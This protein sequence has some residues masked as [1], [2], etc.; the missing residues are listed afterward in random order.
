MFTIGGGGYYDILFV[1]LFYTHT[2][3]HTHTERAM[4]RRPPGLSCLHDPDKGAVL[5]TP[6][7]HLSANMLSVIFCAKA[8]AR[9]PRGSPPPLPPAH[10]DRTSPSRTRPSVSLSLP[11]IPPPCFF[12]STFARQRQPVLSPRS[13]IHFT[14]C[15]LKSPPLSLSL[16]L[17]PSQK[18]ALPES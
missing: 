4:C 1:Y 15:P 5:R 9:D 11:S 16:S 14:L 18:A 8:G 13:L 7:C 12:S 17:P 3:T 10:A 6:G 2:H